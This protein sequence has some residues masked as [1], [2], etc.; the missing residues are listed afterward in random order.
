MYICPWTYRR[1]SGVIAWCRMRQLRIASSIVS[2]SGRQTVG[3]AGHSPLTSLVSGGE[4]NAGKPV[5]LCNL[6]SADVAHF[7]EDSI[8]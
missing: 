4:P 6:R 2:A 8:I 1:H 5:Q 7:D 3:S